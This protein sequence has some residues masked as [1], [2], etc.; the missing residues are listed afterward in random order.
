LRAP[1]RVAAGDRD[2][3]VPR[4]LAA[5]LGSEQVSRV[6]YGAIIGLALVA[7]LE[8]HPPEAAAVAALL[9]STAFAVALA[10]LYSEMLGTQ[11]RLRRGVDSEHRGRIVADVLAVAVGAAFPAVFFLF[12]AAGAMELDTAFGLAKWS[13]LALIAFYGFWAGRLSGGSV[14]SSLLH[15]LAVGAIGAVIIALK[16]IIH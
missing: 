5:H 1:H 7:A 13:G 2:R 3:G 9:M 4:F 12:A 8:A 16:A 11:V 15:A 6:V 14:R 10:E